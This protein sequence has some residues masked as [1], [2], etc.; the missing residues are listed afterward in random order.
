MMQIDRK[1]GDQIIPKACKISPF[2]VPLVPRRSMLI[3]VRMETGE[4]K[5]FP[6]ESFN[7]TLTMDIVKFQIES[8]ALTKTKLFF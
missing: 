6:V 7:P 1:P 3:V 8:E 5:E 2:V 4:N